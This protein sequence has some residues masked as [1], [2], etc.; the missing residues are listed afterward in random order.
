MMIAQELYEGVHVGEKGMH[1]LITYM[2]TDSVRISDDARALAKTFICT[3]Y[4]DNYYPATPNIYK[5][6]SGAQDAHEA[7]R[8]TDPSLVP[9]NVRGKLSADQYKL[10][11]LHLGAV[12]RKSDE[13][14]GFRYRR[15][16]SDVRR[17]CVPRNGTHNAFP[18]LPCGLR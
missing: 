18:G 16:R 2:R 10:Y 15:V 5:S 6:K 13:K 4:G 7:I 14:C 9:E 11:K 8:P 1:G 12:C 3:H 17:L